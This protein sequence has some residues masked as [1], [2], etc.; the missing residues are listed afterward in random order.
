MIREIHPD[1]VINAAA[2]TAVD[3]AEAE[4][5]AATVVNGAAPSAMARAAAQLGVPFVQI[6][7]DYVFDGAGDAPFKPDHPVAPLDAYGRSKLAGEQGVIAAGGIHAILRLL[8]VLGP[9]RELRE[10]HA[11]ALR[12]RDRHQRGR[13]PD[14]RAHPAR[15]IA[16]ACLSIAYQLCADPSKG[17]TYHFSGAPDVSWAGF[18]RETFAQAGRGTVVEDIPTAAYPTP[19]RRPAN[20]RLDCSTT[21]K[22]FGIARPDWKAELGL[23][24]KDLGV[25][26]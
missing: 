19:A 20:S 26:A 4:E 22:V 18:A 25:S 2:W 16:E 8:G 12:N 13:R 3:K 10:D 23:V 15:A 11:A 1:A 14:R 5:A 6:S 21:Q 9:W 7:T 17:G 24:L